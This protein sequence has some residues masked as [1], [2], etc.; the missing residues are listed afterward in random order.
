MCNSFVDVSVINY[1]LP[2]PPPYIKTD[3]V[4]I[5]TNGY[6]PIYNRSA[7]KDL[8]QLMNSAPSV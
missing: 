5:F 1:L 4:I 2:V 8:T 3:L 6:L 7:K